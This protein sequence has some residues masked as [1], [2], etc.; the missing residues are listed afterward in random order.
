LGASGLRFNCAAHAT[1]VYIRFLIPELAHSALEISIVPQGIASDFRAGGRGRNGRSWIV[2]CGALAEG[3]CSQSP[4]LEN[5]LS[6]MA[7]GLSR[8]KLRLVG[9]FAVETER[10]EGGI[11]GKIAAVTLCPPPLHSAGLERGVD[12]VDMLLVNEAFAEVA[13]FALFLDDRGPQTRSVAKAEA[14]RSCAPSG[15]KRRSDQ[16][17]RDTP[18]RRFLRGNFFGPFLVACFW[19][20]PRRMSARS[21]ARDRLRRNCGSIP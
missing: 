17:A 4:K 1:K 9:H 7:R 3:G 12:D 15:R 2:R 21:A 5:E 8:A 14:G 13:R 6:T 10:A 11:F 19:E 18:R 20:I 16:V